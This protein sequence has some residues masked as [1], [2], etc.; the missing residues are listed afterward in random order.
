MNNHKPVYAHLE[1][2]HDL[3][4]ANML[5][6]RIE[7]KRTNFSFV[8]SRCHQESV[9]NLCTITY[10]FVCSRCITSDAHKTDSYKENYDRTM[11]AKYG[12][13]YNDY[14]CKKRTETINSKYGGHRELFNQVTGKRK[15]TLIERY[16][17]DHPAKMDGFTGKCAQTKLERYGTST[18]N[19]RDKAT[20]TVIQKYGSLERFYEQTQEK[21][22]VTKMMRYG[23]STYNNREQAA[24]TS[25]ERYGVRVPIQAK[26]IGD[27]AHYKYTYNGIK[28]DSSYDLAFYIWLTDHG[29]DFTYNPPI[30]FTYTYD[31]KVHLYNPDFQ[32]GDRLVELKGRQ[33]FKNKNPNGPMV[34]PYN[35]SQDAL[36]EAKHQCMIDN[37][38]EIIVDCSKYETYVA[39][40]YGKDYIVGFRNKR[41]GTK[42]VV[43][44]EDVLQQD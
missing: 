12:D 32:I 16:G 20:Q 28:F 4:D 31:N 40:T 34:N 6:P 36:Y 18:Y 27:K 22:A 25:I 38:V 44:V 23:S 37:N 39:E 3:I 17:V 1:T 33:F 9:R 26:P 10:P 5:K 7:F 24:Q 14:V 2:E 15:S 8:C 35:H 43:E 30:Q 19:N 41:K 29:V 42:P 11:R 13:N 21:T